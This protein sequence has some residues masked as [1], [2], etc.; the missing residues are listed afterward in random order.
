MGASL[1]TSTKDFR[2]YPLVEENAVKAL[3]IYDS[4][5]AAYLLLARQLDG[6]SG[7]LSTGEKLMWTQI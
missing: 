7:V 6:H 5:H 1:P 2:N 4:S 3:V